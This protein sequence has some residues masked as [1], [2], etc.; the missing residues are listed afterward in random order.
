MLQDLAGVRGTAKPAAKPAAAAS[1]P[2]KPSGNGH[3]VKTNGKSSDFAVGTRLKYH[4]GS[5][6]INGVIESL[7]PAVVKLDDTSVIRTSLDVLKA[8]G[9]D[10]P[11]ELLRRAGLDLASP[12]PYQGVV[13]AF[14]RALDEAEKLV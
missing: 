11:Y 1:A 9:S 4:D 12:A 2:A 8:G 7:E 3:A 6:W 5:N 10:H 14:N 13:A